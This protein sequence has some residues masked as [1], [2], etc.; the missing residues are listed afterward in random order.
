MRY[1]HVVFGL[2]I[3]CMIA[4]MVPLPAMSQGR[5]QGFRP[6]PY[7]PYQCSAKVSASL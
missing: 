2:A 1:R 7:S 4:L 3:M 5:G 6:C